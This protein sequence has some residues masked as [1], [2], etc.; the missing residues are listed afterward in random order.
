MLNRKFYSLI[1]MMVFLLPLKAHAFEHGYQRKTPEIY[2]TVRHELEV[3]NDHGTDFALYLNSYKGIKVLE[4]GKSWYEIEYTTKKTGKQI[5][6]ITRSDFYENCLIYDGRDK[7]RVADGDYQM[8][9]VD[10]SDTFE[11]IDNDLFTVNLKKSFAF[12]DVFHCTFTYLGDGLYSIQNMD[13][14]EFLQPDPMFMKESTGF[15]G[16]ES[17]AGKFFVKRNGDYFYIQD[18]ITRRSLGKNDH[19]LICY[20]FDNTA[21]W[22]LTRYKKATQEE[23]LRVFAQYD[24]EWADRYYGPGKNDDPTTNLFCTSACGIFATMNAIYASTGMYADPYAMADYAVEKS[25]RILDNGT[26]S[27][28]FEAIAREFGHK[29]G[30]KY[31]GSGGSIDEL[32]KKLKNG[33]VAIAHVPGHYVSIA[34]YNKDKKKFLLLDSHYLPKRQTNAYGDWISISDLESG[35]LYGSMYYYYKPERPHVK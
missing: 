5:G 22:R 3:Y 17:S 9:V 34:T 12:P 20:S 32:I 18:N 33:D 26:D 27:G 25:Y 14:K 11:T 15:W 28:I 24:A 30:F 16:K 31:D 2:A 19:G 35:A 29:Y 21:C 23:S 10:S 7:Q 13:T 1:I 4:E 8:T 6:Y